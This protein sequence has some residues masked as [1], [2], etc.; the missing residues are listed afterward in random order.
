MN[1]R[2]RVTAFVFLIAALVFSSALSVSAGQLLGDADNNS[3][4]TIVDAS[5]I[6][7]YL[8]GMEVE[9]LNEAAA[10]IDGSNV[11][12]ITDATYIQ[13]W[14]ASLDIPYPVGVQPTEPAPTQPTSPWSTDPEGWGHIIF[15]P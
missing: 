6:Q 10:D 8:A 13:R 11:I 4:V 7:A 2:L 12:E 1:F 14:A 5:C 3:E 9:V 15:Q